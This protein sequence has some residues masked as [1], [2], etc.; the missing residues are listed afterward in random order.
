MEKAALRALSLTISH[1]LFPIS[2][3]RAEQVGGAGV[4]RGHADVEE[5]PGAL[6]SEDALAAMQREGKYI[7]LERNR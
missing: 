2:Q 5:A 6:Q 1:F 4:I 7:F 3:P